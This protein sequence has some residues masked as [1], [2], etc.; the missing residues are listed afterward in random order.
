MLAFKNLFFFTKPDFRLVCI[1]HV[2]FLPL[3]ISGWFV[4]LLLESKTFLQKCDEISFLVKPVNSGIFFY[5]FHIF[6]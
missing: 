3:L 2:I 1:K 6:I 4:E 5:I